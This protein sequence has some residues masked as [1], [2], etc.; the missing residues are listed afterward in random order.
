MKIGIIS[1]THGDAPAWQQAEANLRKEGVD[2]LLHAG[3]VLYHGPRNPLVP[4][5]DPARLAEL[6]NKCPFPLLIARGNCDAQI[7]EELVKFPFQNYILF[8]AGHLRIL[9]HHGHL[10]PSERALLFAQS[11]GAKLCV[12]GHT[13]EASLVKEKGVTLFNPGSCSLPKGK[14]GPT[15]ALLT[16]QKI[17]LLD[18]FTGE[19]LKEETLEG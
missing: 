17:R 6:L 8:Q 11:Y 14:F 2:L 13:H 5:Y 3:D 18:L 10:W 19:A 7:D 4:G 16:G 1:D 9:A 12:S 15:F